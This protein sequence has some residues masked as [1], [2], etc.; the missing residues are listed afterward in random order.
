M[1]RLF[2]A[3]PYKL[4]FLIGALCSA[5]GIGQWIFFYLG[6]TSEYPINTHAQLMVLG[7]LFSFVSGFL[8]TAV[9]RMTGTHSATKFEKA[10]INITLLIF[11]ILNLFGMHEISL[12]VSAVLFIFLIAYFIRRKL[13]MKSRSLPSGFLFIPLGLVSGLSGSLLLCLSNQGMPNL[14]GLGKL[15]LY[16]GF[17]LNLIIGLGSRLIPVLTRKTVA[18]SPAEIDELT[19]RLFFIEALVFNLS[20]FIE[21]FLNVRFGILIR[22]VVMGFVIYKNFRLFKPMVERS[23]LGVGISIA[24]LTFPL[25]YFL[26]LIFPLYRA[27]IIHLLYISGFATLTFLVSVRVSLAHGGASL[28][29]ERTSNSIFVLVGAFLLASVIRVLGPI[30]GGNYI[31]GLYAGAGSLF[32]LGLL[33]WWLFLRF[34]FVEGSDD[35]E[36]C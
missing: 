14:V 32:L 11:L 13:K 17:I 2:R 21:E 19:N 33:S 35:V 27:H 36:K 12:V 34:T 22:F 29:L 20:F 1:I 8:M 31:I 25:C 23:K 16:E 10:T 5:I 15:L 3:E 9:P 4:L 7:F 26:I 18:L 24:S 28:D 6:L 30:L